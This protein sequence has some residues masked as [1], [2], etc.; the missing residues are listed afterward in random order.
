MLELIKVLY[1]LENRLTVCLCIRAWSILAPELELDLGVMF[2]YMVPKSGLSPFEL[3][4]HASVGS[5]R[6][7]GC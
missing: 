1:W 7:E 2:F 6:E 4:I 3:P 5:G